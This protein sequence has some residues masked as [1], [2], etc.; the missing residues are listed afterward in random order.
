MKT[1]VRIPKIETDS[2]VHSSSPNKDKSSFFDFGHKTNEIFFGPSILQPKLEIGQPD[3]PFERE[4]DRVAD[5]VMRMSE[6]GVQMACKHCEEKEVRM[7]PLVQR[8]AVSGNT[9]TAPPEIVSAI[10]S[11]NGS[12]QPLPEQTQQ[13]MSSKIGAD[14]SGVRVHYDNK[15]IQLNRDLG[16]K[17]FTVGNNIFFNQG[18]YAPGTTPG[19]R[20][21]AHELVH[22]LQQQHGTAAGPAMPARVLVQRTPD[23]NEE[24]AVTG[25]R[26]PLMDEPVGSSFYFE[27]GSDDFRSGEERRLRALTA[28]LGSNDVVEVHG[29]ASEEGPPVLNMNLSCLR[30]RTAAAIL[31]GGGWFQSSLQVRG[32][33]QHGATPG[34]WVE[35]RKVVITHRR[36]EPE[37]EPETP[38]A[39]CPTPEE[40][41]DRALAAAGITMSEWDPEHGFEDNRDTVMRVYDYYASLYQQDDDLLWAGMAK[42]AGGTVFGG[43]EQA[44]RLRTMGYVPTLPTLAGGHYYIPRLLERLLL[45]Q[46]EIFLDLAWQHQS[47][48]ERGL[49]CL[50]EWSEESGDEVLIQAWRDI[51]SGETARV[52]RGNRLLLRREQSM[53]LPEHYEEIQDLLDFGIVQQALSRLS[54]SPVPGGRSFTE[55]VPGGNITELRDRWRWIHESMLPKYQALSSECRDAMID[56]PLEKLAERNFPPECPPQEVFDR[57]VHA[58]GE[59]TQQSSSPTEAVS[60]RMMAVWVGDPDDRRMALVERISRQSVPAVSGGSPSRVPD[61]PPPQISYR[62][63]R[64]VSEE[65]QPFVLGRLEAVGRTVMPLDHENI[66]G[67]P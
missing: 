33:Y 59:R 43:M 13:E 17:A 58:I 42:L 55:V 26:E 21:L 16:A 67:L 54:E 20:L 12:G 25:C 45:M 53:I 8:K 38:A 1:S 65:M 30:A 64:W 37:A 57:E 41:R 60:G 56:T 6:P 63:R 50:E 46:Q 52:Q 18:R 2:S 23:L 22:V 44:E 47:Y 36:A 15:A 3:D 31:S 66:A 28:I 34:P 49:D 5:Q 51:A 24:G 11:K 62:F 19:R 61:I 32:L 39:L 29:F 10:H 9:Q 35:W 7:K 14:F 40:W 27:V 4:A 48:T